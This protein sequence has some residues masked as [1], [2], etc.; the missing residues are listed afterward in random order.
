MPARFRL[1]DHPEGGADRYF[2][3]DSRPYSVREHRGPWRVAL[4]FNRVPYHPSCGIGLHVELDARDWGNALVHRF[5]NW[6]KRIKLDDMG[7]DA[8]DAAHCAIN[9]V[10]ECFEEESRTYR[11][12]AEFLKSTGRAKDIVA[13]AHADPRAARILRTLLKEPSP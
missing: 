5:R 13:Q 2:L 12:L 10:Q 4:S 11:Q 3:V 8:K 1:F 9:F 7:E 6:G